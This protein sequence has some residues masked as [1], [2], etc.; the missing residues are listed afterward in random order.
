MSLVFVPMKA[1]HLA[2]ITNQTH[3][4]KTKLIRSLFLSLAAVALVSC[5]APSSASPTSAVSCSKC[6]TVSFMAPSTPAGSWNKGFVTLKSSTRMTC[7]DCENKVIAWAKSGAFT[8]H[9]CKSC[10]GAM[11][12][13]KRH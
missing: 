8:E 11:Q 5:Q 1:G 10:G 13:C 2:E 7:P 4:M 9:T 12:H 3:I 6:G